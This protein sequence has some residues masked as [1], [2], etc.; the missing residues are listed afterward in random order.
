M[1]FFSGELNGQ[2]ISIDEKG[3]VYEGEFLN[4]KYT[5]FGLLNFFN[6]D[7]YLGQFL[8]GEFFGKG[9]L[10]KGFKIKSEEKI[11]NITH[12][13]SFYEELINSS[14]ISLIQEQMKDTHEI[15]FGD[16]ISNKRCGE[17]ILIKKTSIIEGKFMDDELK[18]ELNKKREE[19]EEIKENELEI[20]NNNEE[21]S[22]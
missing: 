4:G 10:T 3:N 18:E 9:L 19:A 8:D 15:Y 2:G 5:N 13:N 12:F 20:K 11:Q 1:S 17:G 22:N 7:S 14:R 21:N 6:E 16:F